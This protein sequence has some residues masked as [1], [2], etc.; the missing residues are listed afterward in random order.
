MSQPYALEFRGEII[1]GLDRAAVKARFGQVFKVTGPALDRLFAGGSVVIKRNLSRED[2]MRHQAALLRLGVKVYVTGGPPPVAAATAAAKPQPAAAAPAAAVAAPPP[3][4]RPANEATD[5]AG[6]LQTLPF[7]F[8]GSGYEFFRIWIV[9]LLLTVLTLG[10]Y[11]A[12]AKVRTNRYFYGSTRLDDSSF[13][14][15]AKPIP[16]LKG[17]LIAVAVL[18]LFG[19][20]DSIS[21]IFGAVIGIA[22]LFFIPWAVQRS[23]MFRNRMSA[24][25]NV[26]CDF[27]GSYWDAFKVM[28]LWPLAGVL[29]L[30]LA[31]PWAFYKQQRYVIENSRYGSSPFEFSA[32]ASPYYMTFLF[33]LLIMIVG[34]V[35]LGGINALLALVGLGSGTAVGFSPF[36]LIA[37]LLPLLLYALV[38]AYFRARLI[39]V[40]FNH[41]TLPPNVSFH[42]NFEVLSYMRL[43]LV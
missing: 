27:A 6:G 5:D 34:A 36:M 12:W 30:G 13:E 32:G 18:I 10:I 40:K 15:L 37:A 35:V 43:V 20:S 17:R 22:F 38:F 4:A 42:A 9:N 14:Y 24:Y 26:R 21:P 39:N 8:T 19:V 25:R 28:I 1:E 16:I 3:A 31:M 7:E 29:T 23:L 33:T 41:S 2:A 11:S